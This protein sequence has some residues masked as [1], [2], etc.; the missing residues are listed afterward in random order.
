MNLLSLRY[1]ISVAEYSSFT[2]ASEHLFVTQPTLSRQIMDLEE[3]LG[4]QLFVRSRH[5]LTLTEAGTLLLNDAIDIVNRCDSLKNRIKPD[6]EHHAGFLNIGYQSFLDTKLMYSVLKAI[7]KEHPNIDFSLLRGTPPELQQQLLTDKCDLIFA[8]NTCVRSLTGL[9]RINLETNQL[10]IAVPRNHRLAN[11]NS[12][13]LKDLA[14]EDFIMLD[15]KVSPFTVDY[16][17]SLCMK[18]GFSPNATSY[19]TDAEKTLL[20]VGAGKGITFLHSVNKVANPDIKILDIEG[21]DDDLNFV[22]AY[23]KNN[24][25]PMTALFV[26][27]LLRLRQAELPQKLAK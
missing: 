11:Q 18:N 26:D 15:R 19:V 5:E 8:L 3:E 2:K 7:T 27:E 22:L 21:L 23:K 6:K 12:V 20:L 25:N 1:F 17:T 9:E 4:A 13:D 14:N 10:K 16:V 24:T